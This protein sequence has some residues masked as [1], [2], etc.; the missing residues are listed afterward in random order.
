MKFIKNNLLIISGMLI[1]GLAGFLYWKF[2]GCH[3][4]NCAITSNPVNSTLYGF[5]TG[6]LL[7]SVFKKDVKKQTNKQ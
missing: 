4:G 5:V 3:S 6:G 2:V 1:G 7:F